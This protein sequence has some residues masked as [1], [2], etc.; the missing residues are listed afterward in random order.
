MRLGDDTPL[1]AAACNLLVAA[2]TQ[3]A[4]S[5]NRAV[6]SD[7]AAG[8]GGVAEHVIERSVAVAGPA[9]ICEMVPV[10]CQDGHRTSS[11]IA[12]LQRR[13]LAASS[14]PTA[15]GEAGTRLGAAVKKD[16]RRCL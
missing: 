4:D 9:A 2:R 8:H 6:E 16:R 11:N 7:G 10:R 1:A 12:Q 3:I 13:V 15:V 14:A 5:R